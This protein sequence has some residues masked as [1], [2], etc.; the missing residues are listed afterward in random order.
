[1][2]DIVIYKIVNNTNGK[3]YIGQTKNLKERIRI[4]K[5]WAKIK[6]GNA[7]IHKAINFYGFD[8]FSVEILLDG[9]T[10]ED[11]NIKEVE[12]IDQY[13]TNQR[14]FGYNI[15]IGG[16]GHRGVFGE[17]HPMFGVKRPDLVERNKKGKGRKLSQEIKDKISPLGRKASKETK[18]KMSESRRKA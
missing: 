6:R 10:R 4:H 7:S 5:Y 13:K 1:M 18:K 17:N 2:E 9:L 11:A 3:I 14:D 16:K 8:N 12:L 15:T